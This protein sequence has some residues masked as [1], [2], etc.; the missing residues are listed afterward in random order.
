MTTWYVSIRGPRT[1]E[2]A[3]ALDAGGV[4]LTGMSHSR[5]GLE[6]SGATVEAATADEAREKAEAAI[7][8]LPAAVGDVKPFDT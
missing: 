7:A 1:T 5:P 4:H 3:H 2:L 8:G 6:S